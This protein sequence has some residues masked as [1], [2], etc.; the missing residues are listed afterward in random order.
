[1]ETRKVV[2][3]HSLETRE[4]VASYSLETR[5][6]G[7][8]ERAASPR[9]QPGRARSLAAGVQAAARGRRAAPTLSPSSL[10][11]FLA[12]REWQA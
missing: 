4:V 3:S 12:S 5:K 1:V 2:A 6:G 9:G 10:P 8:E 7:S 11:T